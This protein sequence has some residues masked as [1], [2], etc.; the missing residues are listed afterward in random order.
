MSLVGLGLMVGCPR[1]AAIVSEGEVWMLADRVTLG[2]CW[3]RVV[4]KQWRHRLLCRCCS[5][6]WCLAGID[7]V[8]VGS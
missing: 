4:G 7:G 6:G 5:L 3:S 1:I 8:E 2:F